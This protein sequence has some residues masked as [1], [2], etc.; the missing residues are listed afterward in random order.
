MGLSAQVA[1]RAYDRV[2]PRAPTLVGLTLQGSVFLA[3]SFVGAETR[4]G[5]IMLA[6]FLQGLAMGAWNVP[7]SSAMLG[8]VPPDSFGVGGAFTNV[9]RTVGNVVGQALAAAIVVAV[10]RNQGFD[11]PLGEIED[12]PAAAASFVDGWQL[13][14]WV[15]SGLTFALA[16]TAAR[17][18]WSET[19]PATR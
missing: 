2:G 11:I 8:A 1:G 13:A 4:W 6:A 14:F 5:W 7:N 3:L 18:G 16:V 12:T 19:A 15:A 17:L 9:T 10:L